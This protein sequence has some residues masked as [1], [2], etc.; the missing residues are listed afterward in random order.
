M[1]DKFWNG[2]KSSITYNCS[3]IN[4]ATSFL[5]CR[6][7]KW[8]LTQTVAVPVAETAELMVSSVLVT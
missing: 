8:V 4:E 1:V 3:E 7:T 6:S 2:Q 5:L